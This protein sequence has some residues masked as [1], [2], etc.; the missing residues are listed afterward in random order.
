MKKLLK[1]E[2]KSYGSAALLII[3]VMLIYDFNLIWVDYLG[4]VDHLSE[5]EFIVCIGYLISDVLGSVCNVNTTNIIITVAAYCIFKLYK[6]QTERNS[7][8]R[9][10]LATLPLT[11]RKTQIFYW[12]ADY[13]LVL[14]PNFVYWLGCFLYAKIWF[15]H[16]HVEIPWLFE[17]V[18]PGMIVVAAYL[19]MLLAASHLVESLIVNGT[20]KIFGSIAMLGLLSG[21]LIMAEDTLGGNYFWA[22]VSIDNRS[23][24]DD[25]L[26]YGEDEEY[27]KKY[28]EIYDLTDSQ[29]ADLALEDLYNG[30]YGISAGIYYDGEPLT[31]VFYKMAEGK[32]AGQDPGALS[33]NQFVRNAALDWLNVDAA[34]S[35][36]RQYGKIPMPEV[37]WGNFLVAV[38]LLV[39][40]ILLAGKKEASSQIFYFSFVKY[41]YA[42]LIA[43]MI[44]CLGIGVLEV[45]DSLWHIALIVLSSICIAVLC[46]RWMTPECKR[47]FLPHQNRR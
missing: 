8:G 17:A 23:S 28:D 2:W 14:L 26:Y 15:A 5:E 1:H 9:E 22:F 35:E 37:V 25:V 12:L 27:T 46:V 24:Y 30:E 41:I 32:F 44:C 47:S 43:A 16:Y 7:Y 45:G 18:Y 38:M 3:L 34:L 10:F 29:D 13:A 11:K 21:I 4:M 36:Y 40:E 20:W 42:V 6:Y 33:K 39:W 19:L 31:D